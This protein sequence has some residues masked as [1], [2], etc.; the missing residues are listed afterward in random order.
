M[1]HSL[2]QWLFYFHAHIR[3]NIFVE[4][5]A[6][7]GRERERKKDEKEI[8]QWD[9]KRLTDPKKDKWMIER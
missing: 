9:K 7:T 4:T 6:G 1:F 2:P 3:S 5:Y 8:R